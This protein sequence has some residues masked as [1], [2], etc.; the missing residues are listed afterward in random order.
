[1]AKLIY[2]ADDEENIR[3]LMKAFLENKGYAVMVFPD[4]SSIRQAFERQIPDLIILDIMM[5]GEDGLSVCS[6]IRSRSNVPIIIVSAKDTPLDHVAGITMGS[7]DY[8]SK[9]FLPLELAARVKALFRRSEMSS[10]EDAEAFFCGNMILRPASRNVCIE[11]EILNVTPTEDEFLF[12]LIK[13][14][15]MAVS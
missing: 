7:D 4:G 15:G 1:M 6:Y 9:P 2:L 14:A 8:I 11:R 3:V 12:Y 10:R 5:P 13:R